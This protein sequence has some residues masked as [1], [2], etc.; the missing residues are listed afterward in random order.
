MVWLPHKKYTAEYIAAQLAEI[1]VKVRRETYRMI[2]LATTAIGI[3]A[4]VQ[5]TYIYG[6]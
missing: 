6:S 5:A 1:R 2:F 4:F 3:M